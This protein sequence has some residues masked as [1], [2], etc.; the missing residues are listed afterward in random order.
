MSGNLGPSGEDLR[1][2]IADM[3]KRL[4]RDNTVKQLEAFLACRLIPLDK[5]SGVR[6]TGIGEILRRVIGKIEATGSIQLCAGQNASSEAAIHAVYEMFN[7]ESTEAVLMVDASNAFNAINREEFLHNTKILCPSVSTYVNNCYSSPTDLY[8]QGGRSIKSEE[9]TTQGDPTAMAIYALGITPLLAWLSK[10]SN[11]G[12]S[13]SASKQVA[14]ADD[15]NGVGTVESLKKWWSLPEGEGKKFG[16][17]V[18]AKKSYLIVKEQYKGKEK[19]IFEDTNIKVSTEGHRHLGSVTGSKQFSENYISSL[20]TQWCEEITEL[21]LIARTHPQA[22]YSA[23]TSGYKHKFTFFM[24]TIE[25]FMLPLDKVIKQ[26]LIP[27]LF[28]D[29]QISEELR[30][31]IALPCKLG[32]MGIVHPVETANE[33]YVNSRN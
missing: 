21:S 10:K 19:E 14:F 29:F 33:E 1:K 30:N 26:K 24:R 2:A 20:I 11:E 5:Q 15:L 7:K 17:N 28:N 16:Y 8:I 4:C 32:D 18:N 9:G 31:L 23:F 13:A 25:N 27:A 3:T 12:N 6:P 22:A